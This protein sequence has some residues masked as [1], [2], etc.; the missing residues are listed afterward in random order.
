MRRGCLIA[1]SEARPGL[2]LWVSSER[3]EKSAPAAIPALRRPGMG[4]SGHEAAAL[5]G[6]SGLIPM[7]WPSAIYADR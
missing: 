2:L 5:R 6:H 7:G 4:V 1:A 3:K